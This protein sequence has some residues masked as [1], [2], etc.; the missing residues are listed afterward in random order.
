M[1]AVNRPGCHLRGGMNS[2]RR[3]GTRKDNGLAPDKASSH[4][5][6]PWQHRLLPAERSVC[7]SGGLKWNQKGPWSDENASFVW[8]AISTV[9]RWGRRELRVSACKS[10]DARWI[11]CDPTLPSPHRRFYI[12]IPQLQVM[13]LN[14]RRYRYVDLVTCMQKYHKMKY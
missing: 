7:E 11:L 9:L 8:A 1:L 14:W 5:S 2:T 4:S 12:S 13:D 10:T 6:L 3:E